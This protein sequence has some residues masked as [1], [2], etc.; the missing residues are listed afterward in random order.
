M[1]DSIEVQVLRNAL[2]VEQ[3]KTA[4]LQERIVEL[5]VELAVR[6]AQLHEVMTTAKAAIA[7]YSKLLTQA[8][9]DLAARN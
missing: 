2:C 6:Q 7:G 3:K 9:N 4:A 1:E 8:Q 5:S